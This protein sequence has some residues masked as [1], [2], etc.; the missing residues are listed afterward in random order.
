MAPRVSYTIWFSQRTGSSL[1]TNALEALTQTFTAFAVEALNAGA[2]GLFFATTQWASR[3]LLSVEEYERWGRPYDLRILA[4]VEDAPFNLLHVC[5][6]E[7]MLHDLADY[8]V[9]LFNWGFADAGN[10]DVTDGLKRLRK[11]VI[12]GVDRKQ[13]LLEADPKAIYSKVVTL[14]EKLQS[15]PWGCGPD[16][17]IYPHSKTENLRAVKAAIEGTEY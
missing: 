11:P 6:A 3:Q 9:A 2:D 16:C 17:S 4:Q 15:E 5:S 12:G 7:A 8:P 14:K 1:L 13:D 10:P